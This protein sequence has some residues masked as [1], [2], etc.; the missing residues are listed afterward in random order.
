MYHKCLSV[1]LKHIKVI[2]R[3]TQVGAYAP[4]RVYF[5]CFSHDEGHWP[6]VPINMEIQ[7][8]LFSKYVDPRACGAF[9]LP[10]RLQQSIQSIREKISSANQV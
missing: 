7:N 10:L 4:C 1:F 8:L 9:S 3:G 6:R 2:W 5:C